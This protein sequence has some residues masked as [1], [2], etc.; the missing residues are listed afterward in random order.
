M[1]VTLNDMRNQA[2]YTVGGTIDPRLD[3][4]AIC[5]EAGR[6]LFDLHS[7]NWR[8]RPPVGVDFHNGQG[9][10]LLPKDFGS[11]GEVLSLDMSETLSYRAE[12]VDISEIAQLRELASGDTTYSYRYALVF[13][14]QYTSTSA[15]DVPRLEIYPTP[16]SDEENAATLTYRASWRD[17]TQGNEVANVPTSFDFLLKQIVGAYAKSYVNDDPRE[18]EMIP[19]SS[20]FDR[21]ARADGAAMA[22][23]GPIR[24]GILAP[25][26]R[27][28]NW[29]FTTTG[30]PS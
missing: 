23:L 21:M 25:G 30:L 8:L 26:G 6:Y 17:L 7:W 28:Y 1:S 2:Q 29:N 27:D 16:T 3:V 4:D 5:N 11:T 14:G 20:T 10:V 12:P 15:P 13:P 24:G 19:Q 9:F 22:N 18:L